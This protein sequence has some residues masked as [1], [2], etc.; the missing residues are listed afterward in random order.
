MFVLAINQTLRCC[1]GK[2][3]SVCEKRNICLQRQ[4]FRPLRLPLIPDDGHLVGYYP[5][6][7]H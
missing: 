3:V 1:Q 6:Y 4:R 7:N 2:G 5:L